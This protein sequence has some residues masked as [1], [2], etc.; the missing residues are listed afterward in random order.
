MKRKTLSIK[1]QKAITFYSN[2]VPQNK[3]G[4]TST[5]TMFKKIKL[6][7]ANNPSDARIQPDLRNNRSDPD[8]LPDGKNLETRTNRSL[9]QSATRSCGRL[10]DHLIQCCFS[11]QLRAESYFVDFWLYF[12]HFYG[13]LYN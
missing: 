6:G 7:K 5:T 3:R 1:V 8:S 12:Y 9:V 10:N 2:A 13:W 4:T 11:N